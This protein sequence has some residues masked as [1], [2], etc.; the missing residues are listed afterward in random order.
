MGPR[1]KLL[2]VIA[3]SEATGQS[4]SPAAGQNN[5]QIPPAN[6]EKLR[7]CP[8]RTELLVLTRGKLLH[9]IAR[10]EATW[11]SAS[12]AA[13][14]NNVQIPPANTEK[15]RICPR[16]CQF[17]RFPCGDADCHTSVRTGSQ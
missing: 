12:P 1:G 4:A 9:V 3:R 17:A 8:G 15:L 2:H 16:D 13:G 14:Q 6:T 7:I 11:Q 10:S 5:V